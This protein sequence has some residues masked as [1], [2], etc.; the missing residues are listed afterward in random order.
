MR[1][2]YALHVALSYELH[3]L[4][5]VGWQR[6]LTRYNIPYGYSAFAEGDSF[7][8]W[9]EPSEDRFA[10][11]HGLIRFM[12][13]SPETAWDRGISLYL[14]LAAGNSVDQYASCSPDSYCPA[15][16]TSGHIW[17]AQ[18]GHDGKRVIRARSDWTEHDDYYYA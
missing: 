16:V 15:I 14:T 4:D 5:S 8:C 12:A 11:R 2:L 18:L 3:D 13:G 6:H 17:S 9:G 10:P 7:D 1:E